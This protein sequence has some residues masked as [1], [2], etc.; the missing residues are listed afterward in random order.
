M[1]ITL[2][3]LPP[4]K[5]RALLKG[6]VL[7]HFQLM[8]F[9]CLVVAV[10]LV[11]TLLLVRGQAKS[12]YNDVKAR[13][14]EMRTEETTDIVT[15]ITQ[16]NLYL[17]G[18]AELQTKYV[19]WVEVVENI[20]SLVPPK[21]RLEMLAMGDDGQIHLTG[22]AETRDDALTLLKR[23]KEASYLSDVVSPLS[24][25]LQRENVNFD[26]TMKYSPPKPPGAK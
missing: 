6:V 12:T 9:M 2:N 15:E 7:G 16:A 4:A 23:L 26:F 1:F 19:S 25:I 5:K 22:M 3:L 21:A 11:G 24:N 14:A 18:V 13:A 8:T 20:A 10:G 17:K